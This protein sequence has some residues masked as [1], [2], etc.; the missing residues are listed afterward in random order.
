MFFFPPKPGGQ[1]SLNVLGAGRY[2]TEGR[3]Q[4]SQRTEKKYPKRDKNELDALMNILHLFFS[5]C[6]RSCPVDSNIL[7]FLAYGQ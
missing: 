6:K 2:D 7:F 3:E 4:I 1:I 5:Q